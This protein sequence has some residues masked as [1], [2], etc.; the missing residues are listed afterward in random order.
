[1]PHYQHRPYTSTDGRPLF[2]MD[3]HAEFLTAPPISSPPLIRQDPPSGHQYTSYNFQNPYIPQSP[4][5]YPSFYSN[6]FGL[7]LQSNT[8]L[9]RP[10]PTTTN[11]LPLIL[12]ICSPC[13]PP[14]RNRTTPVHRNVFSYS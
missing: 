8:M 11:L 3:D 4:L 7:H 9:K 10:N 6:S 12:P 5:D 13:T 14:F 2:T 1:M